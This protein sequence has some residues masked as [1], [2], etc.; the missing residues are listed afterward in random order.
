M[1]TEALLDEIE[2][3]LA[4]ARPLPLTASV[5]VSRGDLEDLVADLRAALPE[6]VREA[7]GSCASATRSSVAPLHDPDCRGL[8]PTCGTD[9]NDLP[10]HRHDEVVDS[11][12]EALSSLRVERNGE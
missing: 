6:E 12:W 7:A 9:L 11:R 4:D 2:T 8:C 3:L 10:D 1:D 5:I